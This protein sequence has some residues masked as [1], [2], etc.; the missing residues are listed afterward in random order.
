MEVGWEEYDVFKRRRTS[1]PRE[2]Y[3]KGVWRLG[4]IGGNVYAKLL[5][6]AKSVGAGRTY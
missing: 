3:N 4:V 1:L 2:G 5:E 6:R